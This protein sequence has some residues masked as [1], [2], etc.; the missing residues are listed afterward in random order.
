M[1]AHRFRDSLDNSSYLTK[2]F[3]YILSLWCI[4]KQMIFQN[5]IDS[6]SLAFG[7]E[8]SETAIIIA[9]LLLISISLLTLIAM[10]KTRNKI[11]ALMFIDFF[12]I[13]LLIYLGWL[14]LFLGTVMA[15]VFA[16]LGAY[17][18]SRTLGG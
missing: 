6:V 5:W 1:Y 18:V 7:T 13:L 4:R 17:I 11:E 15:L 9:F 3:F 2:S 16:I 12:S 14:P 8:L 10:G